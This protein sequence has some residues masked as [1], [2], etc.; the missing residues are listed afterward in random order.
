MRRDR[1]RLHD[2]LEALDS[3]SRIMGARTEAE[4]LADE[5]VRY[6]A[7]QRLTVVGEAAARLGGDIRQRY[8]LVPWADVI[9]FRNILVHEYFGIHWPIVWLTAREQAPSLRAQIEE[10]LHLEFPES[11]NA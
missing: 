1:Q 2:I 10:I 3:L 4:F 5:V 9:A 11:P 6:A 7:A 8:P